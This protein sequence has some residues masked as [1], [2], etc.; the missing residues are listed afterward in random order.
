MDEDKTAM[1]SRVTLARPARE[2]LPSYTAALRR[3]WSPDSIRGI[4]TTREQLA[5]IAEDPQAF[6]SSLEARAP[7]GALIILPDG[8]KAPRIPGFKRWLWDG[9]FCGSIGLRWQVGTG[10]LP[11]HVLGHVGYTV[12]PWKRR[13]GYATQALGLLLPEAKAEGLAYVEITTDP[14]NVASRRVVEA[15]RGVLVEE[16]VRPQAYGGT[17]AMRYRI[18]L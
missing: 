4:E 7:G 18:E 1:S 9:E 14:H 8:S 17:L 3:G 2:H 6:L 13:L 15:N 5:A 11:A 12:V 10:T 16:F